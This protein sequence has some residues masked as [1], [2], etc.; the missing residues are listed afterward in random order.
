MTI[1]NSLL[2]NL[3]PNPSSNLFYYIT[4]IREDE[5]KKFISFQLTDY[6]GAEIEFHKQPITGMGIELTM[7]IPFRLILTHNYRE[8]LEF[9][10]LTEIVEIMERE[11]YLVRKFKEDNKGIFHSQYFDDDKRTRTYVFDYSSGYALFENKE[12][13]VASESIIRYLIPK[14]A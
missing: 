12:I 2:E 8:A 14:A 3:I 9:K 5:K 11:Y 10:K 6:I 13:I 1:N 7:E 4:E